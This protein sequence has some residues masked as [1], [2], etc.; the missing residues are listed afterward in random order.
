MAEKRVDGH[1]NHTKLRGPLP[2]ILIMCHVTV[3]KNKTFSTISD[4][5]GTGSVLVLIAEYIRGDCNCV[6]GS[7]TS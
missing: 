6:S 4:S 7:D 1:F 5:D 2:Q 3:K